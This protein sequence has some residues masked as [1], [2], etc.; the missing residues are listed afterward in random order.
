M[1]FAQKSPVAAGYQQALTPDGSEQ[2][3]ARFGQAIAL[4]DHVVGNRGVIGVLPAGTVPASFF[5]RVPTALG[6]GFKASIGLADAN[7]DISTAADDG[8]APW[9][10]DDTTGVAG[11]YVQV[12]PAAFAKLQPKAFDRQLVLKVTGAGTNVGLFAID[13][14][15]SNV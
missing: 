11:G 3:R 5:V 15:Y 6:A 7:G 13:L 12:A 4:A 14:V 2:V 1:P 9:L 10:T 8:G